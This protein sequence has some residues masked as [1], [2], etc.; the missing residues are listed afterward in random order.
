MKNISV[1]LDKDSKY[2]IELK[3]E[4]NSQ[5]F[6]K[7][8][9]GHIFKVKKLTSLSLDLPER[10]TNESKHKDRTFQ[11]NKIYKQLDEMILNLGKDIITKDNLTMRTY[12]SIIKSNNK[13]RGLAWLKPVGNSLIIYLRKGKYSDVDKEGKI[14]YSTP[15]KRTFGDYPMMTISDLFE[16]SY[17]FN[18]IKSIYEY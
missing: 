1:K 2:I 4:Y 10:A 5:E 3:E 16:I 12:S 14:I 8:F 7:V 11:E 9:E 17:I 18:I 15:G 13:R 6:L